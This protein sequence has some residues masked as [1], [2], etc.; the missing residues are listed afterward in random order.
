[1]RRWRGY[2]SVI[3][4]RLFAYG[5]AYLP[6][7]SRNSVIFCLIKIHVVLKKRPL[8]GCCFNGP[9][10]H[11]NAGSVV[12]AG[13]WIDELALLA[14]DDEA[15]FDVLESSLVACSKSSESSFLW[16]LA[17][18]LPVEPAASVIAAMHR[19]AVH[20]GN[21]VLSLRLISLSPITDTGWLCSRVVSVLDS[22]ALGPGSYRSCDAV[23]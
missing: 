4:C 17:V 12:C 16:Q 13:K 3:G 5:L 11:S 14:F 21:S 18:G 1:M 23:G 2:L 10:F 9:S 19:S 8:H 22:G 20:S 15:R 6:L 7:P